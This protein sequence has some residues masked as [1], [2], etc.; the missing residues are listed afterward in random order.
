MIT[1]KQFEEA[2]V[3]H[4]QQVFA[5]CFNIVSD[6]A[7]DL[8]QET[9]I[10]AWRFRKSFRGTCKISTWLTSIAINVC[11]YYLRRTKLQKYKGEHLDV[12]E[13][14]IG[15]SNHLFER[16]LVQELLSKCTETQ[17]DSF[18]DQFN[19]N[20]TRKNNRRCA[21]WKARERMKKIYDQ[22]PIATKRNDIEKVSSTR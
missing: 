10:N 19:G 12:T 6:Q 21:A 13:I 17:R 2:Y 5:V 8:A 14:E 7:E 20:G 1:K 16:V 15:A 11:R 18:I 9:F 22:S 4:K 3:K